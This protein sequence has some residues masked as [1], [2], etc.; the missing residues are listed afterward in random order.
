MVAVN[1]LEHSVGFSGTFLPVEG[2]Q[3][4]FLQMGT[5]WLGNRH[6]PRA[7]EIFHDLNFSKT[8]RMLMPRESKNKTPTTAPP[9]AQIK[10]HS[11]LWRPFS[12]FI[13]IDLCCLTIVEELP[14]VQLDDP[15]SFANQAK[16]GL[17][18][19]FT[20]ISDA[21]SP[22]REPDETELLVIHNSE[23]LLLDRWEQQDGPCVTTPWNIQ[24][25]VHKIRSNPTTFSHEP[26]CPPELY[27]AWLQTFLLEE[28]QADI[29]LI[30]QTSSDVASFYK[31]LV[32]AS[33]SHAEFWERY[34][35][36]LHQLKQDEIRRAEI[37]RR[38]EEQ[39]DQQAWPDDVLWV[40]VPD[41]VEEQLGAE[42]VTKEKGDIVVVGQTSSLS[43]ATTPRSSKERVSGST[44]DE[45][46]KDFDLEL[47]EEELAQV[48]NLKDTEAIE[49]DLEDLL[50]KGYGGAASVLMLKSSAKA[51]AP[52]LGTASNLRQSL[53]F[54]KVCLDRDVMIK[55]SYTPFHGAQF[56]RM[57]EKLIRPGR[58]WKTLLV[59]DIGDIL[60]SFCLSLVY[61]VQ[62]MIIMVKISLRGLVWNQPHSIFAFLLRANHD[63]RAIGRIAAGQSQAEVARWFE[64]FKKSGFESMEHFQK[65]ETSSE[66]KDKVARESQPHQKNVA[67]GLY[68]SHCHPKKGSSKLVQKTSVLAQNHGESRF[69]LNT[70]S[71]RVLI[72]RET[73]TRNHPSNIRERDRYGGHGVMVWGGIMLD[74]RTPLHAF[75]GGTL[76]SQRY[77]DEILEPYGGV[78]PSFIFMDD[79]AR[80]HRA[81]MVDEY[82]ESEGIQ[83]M[84]WPAR[85]PDFNL[86]D[87]VWETLGRRIRSRSPPPRTIQELKTALVEEWDLLP[88]E[89]FNC[90]INSMKYRSDNCLAVRSDHTPY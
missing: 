71:R 65:Q 8:A 44:E 66:E 40:D 73:G 28:K 25:E 59:T 75:D 84:E 82:L 27:E 19:L 46:E 90:L 60:N 80:P 6:F 11:G 4:N 18:S 53:I 69:S 68:P 57:S 12:R 48:Q 23:P 89:L 52:M 54:T 72:W 26:Q 70:D 62:A 81:L 35:F 45:W 3:Q 21:L 74:T 43:L 9:S 20:S 33:I 5:F 31:K 10:L 29:A 86:E 15:E 32:P 49:K 14:R 79:N 55:E 1:F 30:L 50:E 78:G 41:A 37:I 22:T 77:R 87:H 7:P 42:V 36:R 64:T 56:V 85:S 17:S 58:L 61:V 39:T 34:Y 47:T 76:T 51:S 2:E 67:E 83:R 24:A 13:L 88:Q 16:S 63:I 38:A